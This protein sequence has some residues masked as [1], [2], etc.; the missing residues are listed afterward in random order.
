MKSRHLSESEGTQTTRK[1]W[2]KY[3]LNSHVLFLLI[4][5]LII[6]IIISRFANWGNRINSEEFFQQHELISGGEDTYDVFLPLLDENGNLIANKSPH[7][8]LFFGNSVF[9]DDRDSKDNVV[10]MI[11]ERTGATVYNCSVGDSY[12]TAKNYSMKETS[13]GLDV[14]NF[15]F[16]V[17]YLILETKPDY[18]DWLEANPDA[19][20][21]PETQEVRRT[22]ETIDMSTV[23]TVAI[24]YD[25]SDYLAG[26]CFY[27]PEN[28]TDVTSFAGNL[29][30]GIELLQEAFP[31]VRIIVM[32]P[33]Y[34]FGVDDNGEYISSDI[35]RYGN[36]ETLSSF[37]L[38]ECESAVSHNV[39]FV[40]NLYGTFNEDQASD[41]L[42]DNL[43]LNQEGREKVVKRFIRAL[44][45]YDHQ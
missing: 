38:R 3:L 5:I 15:Y 40:D 23:D 45:Y 9:A 17:L 43:H 36:G 10:N 32:S 35:K 41:Y 37:T 13:S 12:L 31:H 33:T 2:W 20:I 4:L 6:L 19:N 22:L 18:F 30:A 24:L 44:T 8:I 7:S 34:A 39:T 14:Y 29:E 25:G 1:Q 27:N 21:L 26:H 42:E 16:M 28:R 11:A